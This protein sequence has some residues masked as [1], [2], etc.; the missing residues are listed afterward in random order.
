[1]LRYWVANCEYTRD[2]TIGPSIIGI[3]SESLRK[4]RTTAR[5][6]LG[7]LHDFKQENYVEYDKLQEVDKYM[8]H[9][10]Y[11]YN[12]RVSSAYS[13]F[14]FNR[15]KIYVEHFKLCSLIK[16]GLI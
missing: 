13:D 8:L 2:V 6:L 14:A 11:S 1:M 7:N 9:E 10:L 4:I 12:D 3:V 15:G 16:T 5:F